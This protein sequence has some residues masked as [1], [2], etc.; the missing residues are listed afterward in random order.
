QVPDTW[1]YKWSSLVLSLLGGGTAAIFLAMPA[2]LAGEFG[3]GNVLIGLFFAMII[4]TTLNYMLVKAASNSGLGAELMSRGLG[5]GFYGSA[6]TT[7]LY[8]ISWLI[9]FATETQI[10]GDAVNAAFGIPKN[11]SYIIVGAAFI[12]LVLYG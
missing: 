6:W 12:P 1:R 2:Q 8:W 5:F 10:L 3:I 7:L 4:Q 9:F 11:L